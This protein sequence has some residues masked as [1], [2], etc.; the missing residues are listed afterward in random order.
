MC[1]DENMKLHIILHCKSFDRFLQVSRADLVVCMKLG[2]A[3]WAH[4]KQAKASRIKK[5]KKKKE[6]KKGEKWWTK[7]QYKQL[8]DWI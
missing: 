1:S 3:A 4:L 8:G 2:F 7:F 5:V 6:K